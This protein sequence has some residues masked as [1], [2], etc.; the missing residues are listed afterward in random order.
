MR[1][2][3]ERTAEQTSRLTRW[4]F[5]PGKR[6]E[7]LENFVVQDGRVTMIRR[8]DAPHVAD[9]HA[10]VGGSHQEF[11]EVLQS[12]LPQLLMSTIPVCEDQCQRVGLRRAVVGKPIAVYCSLLAF[13]KCVFSEVE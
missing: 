12:R 11:K 1:G 13:T 8:V 3:T 6:H 7:P 4:E 5:M 10:G 2:E 9:L